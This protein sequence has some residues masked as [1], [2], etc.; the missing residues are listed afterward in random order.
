MKAEASQVSEVLDMIR[1]DMTAGMF[2]ADQITCFADLHDYVDANMYALELGLP[3]GSEV[4][5]EADPAGCRYVNA[6]D[7]AVDKAIRAGAL[8]E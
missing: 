5:T 1:D 7:D 6:L 8:H 4:A 3:F 2:R